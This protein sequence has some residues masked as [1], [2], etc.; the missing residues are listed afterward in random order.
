MEVTSAPGCP[1]VTEARARP[2]RRELDAEAIARLLLV[3]CER[4]G[5]RGAT[6]T[7]AWIRNEMFWLQSEWR[8]GKDGRQASIVITKS[9]RDLPKNR[10][11]P[12]AGDI[13]VSER[14]AR[15]GDFAMG[16][17]PTDSAITVNRYSGRFERVRNSRV[18]GNLRLAH[19]HGRGLPT[20]AR[21][22]AGQPPP[23]P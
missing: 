16:V 1:H 7:G 6:P 4:A 3:F 22:E 12:Q 13:L 2:S 21:S 8:G 18:H 23:G 17:V 5:S 14:T 11:D 9:D 20:G 10:S 15:A 19:E